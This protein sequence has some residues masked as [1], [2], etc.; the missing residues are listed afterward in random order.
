MLDEDILGGDDYDYDEPVSVSAHVIA[1]KGNG[2]EIVEDLGWDCLH[3][4]TDKYY[5]CWSNNGLLQM[6]RAEIIKWELELQLDVNLNLLCNY[7]KE[8][9]KIIYTDLNKVNCFIERCFNLKAFL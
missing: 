2:V 6:S 1:Y 9:N 7:D 5:A 8:K 3:I 4:N